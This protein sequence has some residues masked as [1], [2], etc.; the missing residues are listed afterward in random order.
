MAIKDQLPKKYQ[1]RGPFY[2]DT[3]S[4]WIVAQD[5]LRNKYAVSDEAVALWHDIRAEFEK[6]AIDLVVLAAPPRPLFVPKS[7]LDVVGMPLDAELPA[8]QD[9]FSTYIAALNAAGIVAPDL[10]RVAQ[11]PLAADYYFA[12]DTHWTPMGA[13]V[14]VAHLNAA[15]GNGAIDANLA[16]I[17]SA[18]T[19]DEKGSLAGV[20]KDA[21]GKRP[22]TET[23][24][25]P[26]Y[27]IQGSAASLLGTAPELE[28]LA[29]V[30]T[31]FRIVTNATP[32]GLR[33]R[34]PS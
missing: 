33:M 12:C 24:P 30:G 5:Q 25:A 20:V 28:K 6:H 7:A 18:G 16:R 1:K 22:K 34:W 4:G 3:S 14:S 11:S 27:A 10:S 9:G 31:S 15:M 8:L 26:Q 32:T 17:T 23:V 29:L 13:A 19:Y 21:C 2:S